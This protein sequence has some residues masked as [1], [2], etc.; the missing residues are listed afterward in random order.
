M[1]TI[2]GCT[3]RNVEVH[4]VYLPKLATDYRARGVASVPNDEGAG[5]IVVRRE[6]EPELVVNG[7]VRGP[8]LERPWECVGTLSAPLGN[9]QGEKDAV[10]IRG[11]RLGVAEIESASLTLDSSAP[12]TSSPAEAATLVTPDVDDLR[13]RI[14]V[15]LGGS[16]DFQISIGTEWSVR[17]FS[18]SVPSP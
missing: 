18:T 15:Q 2:A 12:E 3:K 4:P 17:Y 1:L 5:Y 7:H 16:A 11:C 8:R 6:D 13:H 14:G 9:V 10:V